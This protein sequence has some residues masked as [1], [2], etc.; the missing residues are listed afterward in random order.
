MYETGSIRS[1]IGGFRN[2]H[3]AEKS[4]S[5]ACLSGI[6]SGT[7]KEAR[8]DALADLGMHELVKSLTPKRK[9]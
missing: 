5:I 7:Q 1:A 4:G 8:C 2:Q 9:G 3:M 6:A